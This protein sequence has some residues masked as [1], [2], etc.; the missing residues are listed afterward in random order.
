M[1]PKKKISLVKVFQDAILWDLDFGFFLTKSYQRWRGFLSIQYR[2]NFHSNKSDKI[3]QVK[4]TIWNF[5][6]HPFDNYCECDSNMSSHK[7]LSFSQIRFRYYN[8]NKWT[9]YPDFHTF[10]V[11]YIL[12]FG[13]I[14][15]FIKTE[16]LSAASVQCLHNFSCWI[17]KYFLYIFHFKINFFFLFWTPINKNQGLKWYFFYTKKVI[18]EEP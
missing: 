8:T 12:N 1:K 17:W 5:F 2:W 14:L 3:L 7:S 13:I 6:S 10:N 4:Y 18:N 16:S 11:K 15:P 9:F